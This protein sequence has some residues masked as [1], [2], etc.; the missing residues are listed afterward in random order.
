MIYELDKDEVNNLNTKNNQF[1]K[2]NIIEYIESLSTKHFI[3]L[4]ALIDN[5]RI[6]ILLNHENLD[7]HRLFDFSKDII[8]YASLQFKISSIMYIGEPSNSFENLCVSVKSIKALPK[9]SYFYP[10]N[11][12]ITPNIV[13]KRITSDKKISG[14]YLEC[15]RKAL[16]SRQM[17]TIL[18]AIESIAYVVMYGNYT[19]E[20]CKR[21]LSQ[22]VAAVIDYIGDEKIQKYKDRESLLKEE[23]V[24][25]K[26]INMFKDWILKICY[27]VTKSYSND[28]VVNKTA[29][30]IDAACQFIEDNLDAQLS[31][32]MVSENFS[33]NPSYLSKA[34]KDEKEENFTNYI[35]RLRLEKA[36]E[37]ILSSNMK[38][39]DIAMKVGFN[40]TNYFIKK[41]REMYGTTPGLY[42][43]NAIL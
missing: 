7:I 31:L 1:I 22:V 8:D 9:Y 25:V 26:N 4:A 38:V 6:C 41:F 13:G 23:F 11:D 20:C 10:D 37:L 43:M 16:K 39:D 35:N 21:L 27:D 33:I 15:F 24:S 3:C 5:C 14:S 32:D 40:N 28:N 12:I 34:F 42:K 18:Q 2:Y 17:D 30:L 36:R 19:F 29:I